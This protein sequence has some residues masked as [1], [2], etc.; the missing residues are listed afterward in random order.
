[1]K[2]FREKLT[3]VLTALAYLLFHI[4]TGPDLATIASGTF[5]QIMTT[6]PYAVGFTY[7]LIVILR[8]L[9][10]ATPPWDRILRIFFTIGILFAFFFALYEYGDRAEKMRKRQQAKPVTVSRIWRNE[11]PKVPLYWA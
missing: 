1:M 2:T 10:G 11:N 8:H 5:L 7:V 6:L 3:F 9:S 4:R